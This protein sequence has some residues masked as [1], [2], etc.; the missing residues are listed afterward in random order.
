MG[1]ARIDTAFL[2][3]SRRTRGRTPRATHA[4]LGAPGDGYYPYCR[5]CLTVE[6]LHPKA[7]PVGAPEVVA[8]RPATPAREGVLVPS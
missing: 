8:P 3:R 4:F 5:S 1:A 7:V 2:T 6:S